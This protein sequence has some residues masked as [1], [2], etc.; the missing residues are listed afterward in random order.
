VSRSLALLPFEISR[1]APDPLPVLEDREEDAAFFDEFADEEFD[2][3]LD[4]DEQ[5]EADEQALAVEALTQEAEALAATE[6]D[7][8]ASEQEIAAEGLG[9]GDAFESD[10]VEAS[11][12]DEPAG[13][14]DPSGAVA[15]AGAV[16]HFEASDTS[17]GSENT[18]GPDELE[19][20]G[21]AGTGGATEE[22][23]DAGEATGDATEA[24]GDAGESAVAGDTDASGDGSGG[25]VADGDARDRVEREERFEEEEFEGQEQLEEQGIGAELEGQLDGESSGAELD[26]TGDEE[27]VW[28]ARA[29]RLALARWIREELASILMATGAVA[30]AFVELEDDAE[31]EELDDLELA[32]TPESIAVTLEQAHAELG[33]ACRLRADAELV[34]LSGLLADADGEERVRFTLAAQLGDAHKLPRQMAR[35]LLLALGD[36]AAAAAIPEPTDLEDEEAELPVAAEAM[37]ELARGARSLAEAGVAPAGSPLSD[38]APGLREL[39]E[40]LT[41]SPTLLG[42]R[43]RI[44]RGALEAVG[45]EWMPAWLSGLEQLAVLRPGDCQA[46]LV[47]AEYRRLHH[48]QEG[49]RDLLLRARDL[50]TEGHEEATVLAALARLVEEQGRHEEAVQ[51]LRAAVRVD[52][53]PALYLRLG[54]LLQERDPEE[55]ARSLQRAV[56]LSPESAALRLEL[57]RQLTR[58]GETARAATEAAQAARLGQNEPAISQAA[59]DLLRALID[60]AQRQPD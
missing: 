33:L 25:A 18:E 14:G 9:S 46:L 5:Q 42:A 48:D 17:E 31:S 7:V 52:D 59:D 56:V 49:A 11:V 58:I 39:L 21:N 32:L 13:A 16:E 44:V 45:S 26:A 40:A 2:E 30:P 20:A 3:E 60:A 55:S 1:Q 37:L 43:D 38:P 53:D 41:L 10:A 57:A 6:V 22:K 36:D 34:E 50:A 27:H 8:E 47:L 24:T 15:A 12:P 29:D 19:V 54:Q 51:H 23:G 28:L 35:E 4:D